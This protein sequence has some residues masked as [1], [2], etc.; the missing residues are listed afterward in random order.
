MET[1]FG[2]TMFVLVV[3]L[4]FLPAFVGGARNHHLWASIFVINAFLGWTAIGWIVAL[5]MAV[6]PVKEEANEVKA[7]AKD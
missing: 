2:L 4:Y 5:A 7:E 1:L 3:G 6:G